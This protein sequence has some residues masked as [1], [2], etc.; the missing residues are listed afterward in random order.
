MLRVGL[1][2]GIASGKSA[3]ARGLREGL[4]LPGIDADQVARRVVEPGRT[5]FGE[6]VARFGAAVVGPDGRLDRAELGRIVF[7]DPAAR[8]ELEA[9]T[10]PRIIEETAA[11]L[12]ARAREGALVAVFETPLLFEAHL[13]GLFDFVV[14]VVSSVEAQLARSA[15]RDG[16]AELEV[17][18]RLAAQ[19]PAEDKARRAQFV[20]RNDGTLDDLAV[21]ARAL[22]A[23][24]EA[25]ARRRSER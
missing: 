8:A 11:W 18:A 5:A 3:V 2:G 20:L 17:R 7:A 13:E 6:V 10:H 4:G 23:E 19:L 14:V 12:E 24:L 25:L 22:G 1:T 21:Q 16:L 9:I 15:A